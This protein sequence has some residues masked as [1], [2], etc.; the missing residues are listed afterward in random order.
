MGLEVLR[1]FATKLHAIHEGLVSSSSVLASNLLSSMIS[2][3]KSGREIWP[4][5]RN[6]FSLVCPTVRTLSTVP[7]IEKASYL[8]LTPTGVC[9]ISNLLLFP[10]HT[11]HVLAA[12]VSDVHEVG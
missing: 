12:N 2:T 6:R 5:V 7:D 3:A 1:G 11:S 10:L 4:M 8:E 9:F